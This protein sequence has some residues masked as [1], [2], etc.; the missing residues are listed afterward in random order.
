MAPAE[1]TVMTPMINDDNNDY[2]DHRGF[3]SRRK[4]REKEAQKRPKMKVGRSAAVQEIL[5][6][7]IS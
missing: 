3:W 4:M 2:K 1:T 6:L 5:E 7:I